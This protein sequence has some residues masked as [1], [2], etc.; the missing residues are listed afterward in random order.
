M[1]RLQAS[2]LYD[3]GYFDPGTDIT[4]FNVSKI[5]P[6]QC[7]LLIENVR[8]NHAGAY[9]CVETGSRQRSEASLVILGK[10]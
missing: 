1:G 2:K 8:L 5:K 7:D 10:L 6:G 3:S 4:H 9:I